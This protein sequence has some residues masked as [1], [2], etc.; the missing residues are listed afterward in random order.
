MV[1][2]VRCPNPTCQKYMLV[3]DHQKGKVVPCLICKTAI[4][5]AKGP[6]NPPEKQDSVK[7]QGPTP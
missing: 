5:V 7:K 3:E 2:A 4:R 1:F 6:A